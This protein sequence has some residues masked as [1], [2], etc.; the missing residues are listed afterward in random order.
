MCEVSPEL[1][2]QGKL[3]LSPLLTHKFKLTE[4][5]Q[6]FRTLANRGRSRALKAVF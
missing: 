5:K 6:A 4:Y 2:A 1:V 3:D